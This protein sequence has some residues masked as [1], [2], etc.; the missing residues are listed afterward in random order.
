MKT[1][2]EC[3]WRNATCFPGKVAV[4]SGHRQVTYGELWER[5]L[6]AKARYKALSGY[7]EGLSVLLAANNQLEFLYAYFGAH[8]A[9]LVAVPMAE[10][11]NQTRLAYVC[12]M[13]H[14]LAAIGFAGEVH[15]V[16]ERLDWP[17]FAGDFGS[18][19]RQEASQEPCFPNSETVADILFTT[20]TTGVPKGVP[21]TFA[22][23]LAAARHINMYIQNRPEDVELLALPVS[24]SFGLGRVRCCLLNGQTLVLLGSFANVKRLFRLM[25]E[26]RV[27][28]FTMVPA[29]WSFLQKM[30][31]EALAT[32]AGQLRYIEMGSAPLSVEEKSRLAELF[33]TTRVTMHYGLTEASR[34]AFMEFH[35]DV[36]A[37]AS[38]GRASPG[39]EIAIFDAKG[40][41]L[42]PEAEG[43]ICIRGPHVTKG[44]LNVPNSDTF[45]GT[46][47]RTGDVGKLSSEGYLYLSGRLKELINVGGKK[48]APQ[49]V[50]AQILRV[51]GVNDCACVGV[52]DPE[53]V[54]GEVVKACIVREA[55]ST[56]TF[57]EIANTLKGRLEAYK[58]PTVWKWVEAVPR[59]QN[60][61]IQRGLLK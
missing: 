22:N 1:L 13:S 52:P 23:V 9:G 41:R 57:D 61:K 49:E 12:E 59:T 43:E 25:R 31:G 29:S 2:E 46:Y 5:I 55:G 19:T 4:K 54:L 36:K 20:G 51:P 26:E 35:E 42:P 15:G 44:Y 40:G 33:P 56:V 50:D 6:A 53:G 8:L 7:A 48:V 11:T 3:L 14:P 21:L 10:D 39:V 45:H 16:R 18:E 27:T 34:S 60:G 47:F 24:H 28:G 38:V 58:L 32:F 17:M 30:S 37:L